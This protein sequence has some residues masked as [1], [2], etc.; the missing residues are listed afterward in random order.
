M[1]FSMIGLS[2]TTQEAGGAIII[3]KTER[4]EIRR[5]EARVSRTPTLDLGAVIDHRGYSDGDRTIRV[6]TEVNEADADFLWSMFKEEL[7]VNITTSDGYFHGSVS[8]MSIDR[9]QLS[10]TLLVKE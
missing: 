5:A 4:S 7:Y 6:E 1:S 8:A 10:M 3:K 9:G 2:K